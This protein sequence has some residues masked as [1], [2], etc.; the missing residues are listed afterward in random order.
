M[1]V[2]QIDYTAMEEIR[3][4]FGQETYDNLY[5]D[6]D[7]EFDMLKSILKRC[8]K[9]LT[10]IDFSNT[11]QWDERI[12][13]IIGEECGKNLQFLDVRVVELRK[14][15]IATLQTCFSNIEVFK[16]RIYWDDTITDEDLSTLFH[17]NK[18][19]RHLTIEINGRKYSKIKGDFLKALPIETMTGLHIIHPGSIS[20][21][22]IFSVRRISELFLYINTTYIIHTS[23]NI[24]LQN[25]TIIY[26]E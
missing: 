7:I 2:L 23:H 15:C 10:K 16:C 13:K 8:G 9:F 26:F 21:E 22:K 25:H 12:Y 4:E 6:F 14:E 20:M 1:P 11:Y 19:L 17:S 5:K 18:K 3:A 24:K